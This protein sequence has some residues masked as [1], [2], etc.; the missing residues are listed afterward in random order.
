MLLRG[1]AALL[2]LGGLV[3][4]ML[5]GNWGSER[6]PS[7]SASWCWGWTGSV[8]CRADPNAPSGGCSSCAAR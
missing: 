8:W 7:A 1:V 3:Y 6:S 4:A 2:L 5:S